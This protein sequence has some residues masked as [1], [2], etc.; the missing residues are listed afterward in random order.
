[1]KTVKSGAVFSCLLELQ[2]YRQGLSQPTGIF[3]GQ[4]HTLGHAGLA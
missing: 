4:T 2:P 3:C 1:M